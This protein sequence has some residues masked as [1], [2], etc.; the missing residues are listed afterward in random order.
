MIHTSQPLAREWVGCLRVARARLEG[1]VGR[2]PPHRSEPSHCSQAIAL[3]GSS[4]SPTRNPGY[5]GRE[6][7][8][9]LGYNGIVARG[10]GAS[11]CLDGLLAGLWL[12]HALAFLTSGAALW[13][14]REAIASAPRKG[15]HSAAEASNSGSRRVLNRAR[16]AKMTSWRP[17]G[18]SLAAVGSWAL[19][20]SWRLSWPSQEVP[21]RPREAP[22][23]S[24]KAFPGRYGKYGKYGKYSKYRRKN[25]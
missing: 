22:G 5:N 8:E 25:K 7:S 4:N 2:P 1:V 9:S 21:G 17:P 20:R 14:G 16:R 18:S 19:G 13:K 23:G 3:G 12:W 6:A 15:A 10:F 11:D 24:G